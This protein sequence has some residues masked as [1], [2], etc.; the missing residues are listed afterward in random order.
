[1]PARLHPKELRNDLQ[2]HKSSE[3]IVRP[4]GLLASLK[5]AHGV[6][7]KTAGRPEERWFVGPAPAAP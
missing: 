1:M 5:R 6:V 3:E 2:R 7:S 4:L